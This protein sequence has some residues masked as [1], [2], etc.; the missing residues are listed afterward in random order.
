MEK[1]QNTSEIEKAIVSFRYQKQLYI[2]NPN[3]QMNY[4]VLID[5]SEVKQASID[6]VDEWLSTIGDILMRMATAE[7]RSI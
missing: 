2:N 3:E 6:K 1:N 5:N 4:F 7:L